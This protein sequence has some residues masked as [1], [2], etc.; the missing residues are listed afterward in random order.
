[1]ANQQP[2][3]KLLGGVRCRKKIA[4]QIV[5]RNGF[6]SAPPAVTRRASQNHSASKPWPTANRLGPDGINLHAFLLAWNLD[7]ASSHPTL[8]LARS[9]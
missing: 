9:R 6:P 7:G 3:H 2:H 1:M 5:Q 4:S 8:H